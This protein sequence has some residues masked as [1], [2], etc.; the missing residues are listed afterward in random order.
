MK[1]LEVKIIRGEVKVCII[2]IKYFKNTGWVGVKSRDRNYVPTVLIR[3]SFK[4]DVERIYIWDEKTK[5]TEGLNE[6][7]ISILNA[8]VT[9]SFDESEIDRSKNKKFYSPDGKKIRQALLGKT[10]NDAVK[11]CINT[12]LPGNT[13]IFDEENAYLM[14]GAWN[15]DLKFVYKIKKLEKNETAVRTNHG[16]FIPWSGY[17][18][19]GDEKE[20]K[21]RISSEYRLK[22]AMEDLKKVTVPEKMLDAISDKSN[23]NTQLNPLRLDYSDS[24]D[25]LK[26]T[27]QIMLMPHKKTLYFLPIFCKV[28]FDFAKL[29]SND[30]KTFFQILSARDIFKEGYL[31]SEKIISKVLNK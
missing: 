21:S 27:A 24:K 14:E 1:N 17:Q 9:T 25:V 30:T 10:I 8:S 15:K 20:R 5:Y 13:I 19:D 6:Y 22:K 7:G 26:T 16:I 12:E 23:K 4:E 31:N 11:I 18:N 29:D 2:A 28:E 3:Q